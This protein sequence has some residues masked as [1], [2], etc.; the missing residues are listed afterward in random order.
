[1]RQDQV[2]PRMSGAERS[3]LRGPRMI[4][5]TWL[6]GPASVASA[7]GEIGIRA[8]RQAAVAAH[9]AARFATDPAARAAA[10][11]AGQAAGIAHM[12]GH[13]RHAADD[14]VKAV[15]A[16]ARQSQTMARLAPTRGKAVRER[17]GSS[18][19]LGVPRRSTRLTVGPLCGTMTDPAGA[20]PIRGI[21]GGMVP[22]LL[23]VPQGGTG[24]RKKPGPGLA[25]LVEVARAEVPASARAEVSGSLRPVSGYYRV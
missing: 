10:R 7:R 17:D 16:S 22:E 12:A 24:R 15:S 23:P 9:A 4:V 21:A 8:A 20:S 2:H 1:M 18:P 5:E 6:S 3:P 11:A 13:A 19:H 14:A 25:G